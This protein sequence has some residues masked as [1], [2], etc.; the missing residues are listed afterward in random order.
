MFESVAVLGLLLFIFETK[1][2][3]GRPQSR[4]KGHLQKGRNC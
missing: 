4:R 2:K 1:V 3:H